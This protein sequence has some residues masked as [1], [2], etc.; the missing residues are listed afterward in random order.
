MTAIPAPIKKDSVPVKPHSRKLKGPLWLWIAV[1]AILVGLLGWYVY[2]RLHPADDLGTLILG[3][4]QKGDLIEAVSASGSVEPQTGAQVHI[5]A[6]LTGRIKHVYTDVGKTVKAGDV[7]AVLDVPEVEAAYT[8]SKLN[9]TAATSKLQQAQEALVLGKSQTYNAIDATTASL[10][11]SK[12]AVDSASASERLQA[13]VTPTDIEKARAALGVANA[14]LDSAQATLEQTQLGAKLNIASAQQLV[15]QTRAT[16]VLNQATYNRQVVLYKQGFVSPLIVD[17]ALQAQTFSQSALNAALAQLDLTKQKVA[18]DLKTTNSLLVQ[19]QRVV[20][21]AKSALKAAQAEVYATA[22]KQADLGTAM[23]ASK[24]A[25]ANLNTAVGNLTTNSINIEL[26]KQALQAQKV[27]LEQQ[28][29]NQAEWDR[30]FIRTP[31]KGTVIQLAA[32]QGETVAASLAAPTLIVVADLSRLEVE[33]YVDETDIGKIKLGQPATVSVDA[34]PDRKFTGTVSKIA[35]GSTIQVGVIT[36]DVTVAI[37]DPKMQLRPDM[38]ATTTIET[39][40][41]HNALLVPAVAIQATLNG[42]FVKVLMVKDGK[43]QVVKVPVKVGGTDG[44]NV[45][46][47]SGLKDGDQIVLAGAKASSSSGGSKGASAFGGGGGGGR[48]R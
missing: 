43:K 14:G 12:Q 20:E 34:F 30:S 13:A 31:I 4:A 26:V 5:G 29:I 37:Q 15:D 25:S 48:G 39:G 8:Q 19:A 45:A 9:Y 42:S 38:S 6:Q 44:V 35:A 41:L 24:V 32:Q 27:A 36:Y 7:I 23:A 22:A 1:V 33:A 47:L 46:I 3:K 17:T 40:R 2:G 18:A 21:S 16:F 10:T 11:S 28:V